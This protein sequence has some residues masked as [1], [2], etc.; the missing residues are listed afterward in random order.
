MNHWIPADHHLPAKLDTIH[1]FR[2]PISSISNQTHLSTPQH[3]PAPC[4]T[5][6]AALLARQ[7]G[8]FTAGILQAEGGFYDLL[9]G[10]QLPA[11]WIIGSDRHLGAAAECCDMLWLF[12]G[13]ELCDTFKHRI[14]DLVLRLRP[15]VE[16]YI[17]PWANLN[18]LYKFSL[19]PSIGQLAKSIL[20][21]DASH[22]RK[23]SLSIGA[24][25]AFGRFRWTIWS[26][27]SSVKLLLSSV[28]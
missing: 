27:S 8:P 13:A 3:H 25:S 15:E 2:A 12:L 4:H 11:I 16:Y 26:M 6:L 19:K 7:A 18:N 24:F 22:S 5:K 28:A 1:L 10:T 20:Y 23:Q 9:A 17:D 14:G 21:L